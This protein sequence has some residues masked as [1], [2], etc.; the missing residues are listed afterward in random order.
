MLGEYIGYGWVS[1]KSQPH[2][3]KLLVNE[4]EI[5]HGDSNELMLP[6]GVHN[7]TA[8]WSDRTTTTRK[9]YVPQVEI[10][11]DIDLNSNS[12]SITYSSKPKVEKSV[13]VLKKPIQ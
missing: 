1:V 8:S 3:A 13:I 10:N 2:G 7:F 5:L 11:Y 6:I 9:V 12:N 4:G